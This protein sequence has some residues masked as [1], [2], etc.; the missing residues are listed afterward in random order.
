MKWLRSRNPLRDT[1]TNATMV[2]KPYFVTLSFTVTDGIEDGRWRSMALSPLRCP[3]GLGGPSCSALDHPQSSP[4]SLVLWYESVC[5]ATCS[6]C[7]SG[8]DPL[9]WRLLSGTAYVREMEE[10]L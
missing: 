3:S 5:G 7:L 4:P 2:I 9:D 1:A 8:M 6:P 10:L